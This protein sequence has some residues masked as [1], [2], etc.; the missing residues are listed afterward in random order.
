MSKKKIKIILQVIYTMQKKGGGEGWGGGGASD[1]AHL[2]NTIIR[3]NMVS[4]EDL[5][6]RSLIKFIQTE[7]NNNTRSKSQS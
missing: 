4:T 1:H 3:M 7:N 5:S 2:K 6:C